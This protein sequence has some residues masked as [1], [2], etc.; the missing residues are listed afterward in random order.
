MGGGEGHTRQGHGMFFLGWG[1]WIR[2]NVSSPSPISPLPLP[3]S[4][5]LQCY[6]P[7]PLSRLVLSWIDVHDRQPC[8]CV[9]HI[10]IN[11]YEVP[12]EFGY[13]PTPSQ[14]LC[15]TE[16]ERHLLSASTCTMQDELVP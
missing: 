11:V 16:L 5:C 3:P 9:H 2:F 4:A 13:A 7:C 10:L 8:F 14:V 1:I 15:S 6:A 12:S